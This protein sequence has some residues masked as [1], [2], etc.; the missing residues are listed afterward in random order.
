MPHDS[1]PVKS[2]SQDNSRGQMTLFPLTVLAIPRI[3]E[4]PAV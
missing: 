2:Q 4:V 3:D 1:D